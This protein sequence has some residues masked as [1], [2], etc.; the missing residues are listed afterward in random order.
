M[1]ALLRLAARLLFRAAPLPV[2]ATF[3][4]QAVLGVIPLIELAALA[5]A[6]DSLTRDGATASIAGPATVLAVAVAVSSLGQYVLDAFTP[7]VWVAPALTAYVLRLIA[8]TDPADF[9]DPAVLDLQQRAGSGV[10]AQASNLMFTLGEAVRSMA[11]C[12]S[13]AGLL[14]VLDVRLIMIVALAAVPVFVLTRRDGRDRESLWTGDTVDGRM[15]GYLSQ[16][17]RDPAAGP[18]L[19]ELALAPTL[20]DRLAGL[21][22]DRVRLLGELARRSRNRS[23]GV[24]VVQAVVAALSLTILVSDGLG[25]PGSTGDLVAG[26]TAIAVLASFLSRLSAQAGMLSTSAPY[27]LPA[28]ELAARGHRRADGTQ[29][30]P[31]GPVA[32]SLDEVVFA[33]PRSAAPV[34][35]GVNLE[36]APGELVALVGENG[37]GKSTLARLAM[38]VLDADGGTVRVSGTAV[39]ELERAA[40]WKRI[41]FLPQ[42]PVR[43]ELPLRDAVAIGIDASEDEVEH[44]LRAVGAHDLLRSVG[45]HGT[46]GRAW[47]AGHDLSGGQWQRVSLARLVL[48][49]PD[50]WIL[51]EPTANLDPAAERAFVESLRGLLGGATCL[52]ISHRFS[53]VRAADR[54]AVIERHRVS[55]IGTHDELVAAGGTYSRLFA[56]QAAGYR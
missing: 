8:D 51:D 29:T 5:R 23:V 20:L 28:H 18:E 39:R 16:L 4:L 2:A 42:S 26:L 14:A 25:R 32:L 1:F 13:L 56:A 45:L 15:R 11:G 47:D 37:A 35:D 40:L 43:L 3:G 52:F 41:G 9:D 6:V 38:G 7:N 48:R 19:R 46:L 27:L 36:V 21:F 53:T 12:A 24:G 49:R 33:Y 54:I 50:L 44:A 34:L 31:P 55:E 30:A 22:A 10:A 17:L